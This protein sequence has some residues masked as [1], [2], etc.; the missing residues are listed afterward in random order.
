MNFILVLLG[1]FVFCFIFKDAIRKVPWVF[2]L[3]ALA[4]SFMFAIT[5]YVSYPFWLQRLLFLLMQKGTLATAL[6]LIVMYMG[7]FKDVGFV[8]HRFMPTRAALSITACILIL[9]HVAKYLLAYAPRLGTTNGLALGGLAV[10]IACFALMLVLGVTSF[11]VV[12]R[13]IATPQWIKLQKWA[14]LFYALVYVH[15]IFLLLPSAMGSNSS[16][17]TVNIVVYTVLFGAYAV[18]R[19]GKA[20]RDKQRAEEAA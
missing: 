13:H 11:Q 16:T 5:S 15:L 17:S 3:L 12:K 8:K 10:G 2:Y 18:L 7:V 19:V 14:Y 4:L 20:V 9:G 6:F 1:T